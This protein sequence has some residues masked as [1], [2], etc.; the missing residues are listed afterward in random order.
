[1][2][3]NDRLTT[4]EAALDETGAEI[5]AELATLRKQI[6]HV[7]SPD[8]LAT[9]ARLQTKAGWL[10]DIIPGTPAPAARAAKPENLKT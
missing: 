6:Q 4:I 1:M 10:A 5:T 3:I 7:I 9:L 8:A 2:D